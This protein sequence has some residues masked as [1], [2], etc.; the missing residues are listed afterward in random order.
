MCDPAL[1]RIRRNVSESGNYKRQTELPF[2][3][4]E[5]SLAKPL[6]IPGSRR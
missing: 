5:F 3:W 4:S 2:R 1:V 6:I